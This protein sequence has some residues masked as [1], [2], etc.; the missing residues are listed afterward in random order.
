VDITRELS[1]PYVKTGSASKPADESQ[2]VAVASAAQELKKR[3]IEHVLANTEDVGNRFAEEARKIFYKETPDRAIRGTA[4]GEEVLEMKEEGLDIMAI[5][6]P[7]AF[8]E[9]L[10]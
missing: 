1:A 8:P 9:K 2:V 5:P 10:H 6:G 3:F 7:I 4:S